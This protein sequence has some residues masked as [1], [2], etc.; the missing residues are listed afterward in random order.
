MSRAPDPLVS[1]SGHLLK[2]GDG[3]INFNWNPRYITIDL[4]TLYY[5]GDS[6]DR[7]PRG[8]LPLTGSKVTDLYMLKEHPWSFTIELRNGKKYHFSH[9]QKEEAEKWREFVVN[10]AKMKVESVLEK[11]EEIAPEPTAVPE[12][13]G[14]IGDLPGDLVPLLHRLED[15]SSKSHSDPWRLLRVKQGLRIETLRLDPLQINAS[16]LWTILSLWLLILTINY[17]FSLSI[18]LSFGFFALSFLP[19]RRLFKPGSVDYMR[20]CTVID[21]PSK[22][23]FRVLMDFSQR[24][25]WDYMVPSCRSIETISS[26]VDIYSLTLGLERRNLMKYAVKDRYAVMKR[27]WKRSELD[28]YT[29]VQKSIYHKE[30]EKGKIRAEY[31]EGVLI[32]P[33]E[34]GRCIV[35]F[36]IRFSGSYPSILHLYY[37][38]QRL[39]SLSSLREFIVQ[40]ICENQA[41][42]DEQITEMQDEN[43]HLA[44]ELTGS[45]KNSD[46]ILYQGDV[47]GLET[48][49]PGYTR[50]KSGGIKCV[51]QQELDSQKGIVLELIAKAGKQL[52]KGENVVGISLPVRIFEPRSTLERMVDW[53]CTAPVYLMNASLAV[54]GM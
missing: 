8:I 21:A 27:Y 50:H 42:E 2:L 47:V 15:L 26:H 7:N 44:E 45:D 53:W 40:Q 6:A 43:R 39:S 34:P 46:L 54:S 10:A 19:L 28:V 37:T 12:R 4:S 41:E 22:D 18:Y 36:L 51:N 20:A 29:I 16:S 14:S 49:L 1:K 13:R 52:M 11:A 3:P 17:C 24:P 33:F 23:I 38:L 31:Q 9:L 35:T 30:E 32:Q 48:R 25:R 5:Y